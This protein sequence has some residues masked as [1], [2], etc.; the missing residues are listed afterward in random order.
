MS[1]SKVTTTLLL[2]VSLMTTAQ[3]ADYKI[4]TGGMH[5]YIEFKVPHMGFSLLG[6]RFNSFDGSFSW[7]KANP[8]ASSIE[9]TIQTA[10]I[11]TNHEER[12][13]HLSSKDFL[14][15]AEHPTA[16]FK[17]TG[18]EGD[19]SGGKLNGNFTLNGVTK[20]ITI[21]V[22]AVGE[23]KDPWGGYRAG[24]VGSTTISGSDFGYTNRMFPSNIELSMS[25]EGIQQ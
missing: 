21:D 22:K 16:T 13:N 8:S 7:D 11:D 1:I 15:V 5:A 4:D 23:G 17:S 10:S 6:G 3:A 9:V 2:V 12:D 25:I 18:Y 20:P 14:N 24:F 19:A